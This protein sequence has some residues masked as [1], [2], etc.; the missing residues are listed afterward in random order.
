MKDNLLQFIEIMRKEKLDEI[1]INSFSRYYKQVLQGATGMLSE[2]DIIPPSKSNIANYD[3]LKISTSP[4]FEKLVVV[5]LNGGLGTSMGL[6]KA[7][8]LLKVKD[9]LNFLDIIALQILDLR[10]KTGKNIP[11][12]FMNSFNTRK[13]TLSYLKKYSELSLN[14]LPLD[15]I[16]NKFPK[17]MQNNL[18][19]LKH[20][21]NEL[22]WN[23]PGHGEIYMVMFI[24][25]ILDKLLNLGF[26]YAFI[27]NSDNLGAVIDGKILNYFDENKL[28]FLMEVCA[29]TEM[30]RKGGHLAQTKDGR[31]ILREVAQCPK[32][33]I[34]E[35]QNI[36]KYRY[37]NT[38][39]I[40]VNLRILKQ[41]LVES[42][43]LLPLPLIL[44]KKSVEN[45]K[46]YQ[47]ETAMGAAISVYEGS[48]AIKIKRDRFIPVKKTNDLLTIWSDAYDLQDDYKLVLNEN[49]KRAPII[50]LDDNY[51]KTIYQL[52]EHFKNG[53]PSLKKCEYLEVR[54]DVYFEGNVEIIGNVKIDTK[55]RIIFKNKTLKC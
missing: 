47:I 55:E 25:G 15:F 14:Q 48:K 40:W 37:F 18:S 38:N 21:N 53:V 10:K 27:S 20:I 50:V 31:L 11:V 32:N 26:E 17:I 16:Q 35:F 22:N 33:E 43:W 46:V 34:E 19:P 30:D 9:E 29:R 41:K 51:F 7:K 5:K 54:G 28:P 1:V 13:D 49:L 24:S 3:D 45:K 39:N 4:P 42:N 23:P 12:L 6:S 52:Q 44:N 36:K 8:S 2:N